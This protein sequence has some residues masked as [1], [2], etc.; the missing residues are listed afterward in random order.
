MK[1]LFTYKLTL[2][3]AAKAHRKNVTVRVE[4]ETDTWAEATQLAVEIRN[5]YGGELIGVQN[6]DHEKD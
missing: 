1:F 6:E 3:K 5:T 2:T 4:A